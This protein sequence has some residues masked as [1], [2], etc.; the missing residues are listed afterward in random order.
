MKVAPRWNPKTRNLQDDYALHRARE[1]ARRHDAL[2]RV[3]GKK[4]CYW[5]SRDCPGAVVR[6]VGR[7]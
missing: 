3:R 4:L 1:G 7:Q 2:R 6:A 5:G